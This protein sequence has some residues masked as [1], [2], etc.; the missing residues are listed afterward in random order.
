[1]S[2]TENI[3]DEGEDETKKIVDEGE[4]E[5]DDM[6]ALFNKKDSQKDE[7]TGI[8]VPVNKKDLP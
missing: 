1:M 7:A 4:D 5:T 6:E 8:K 2:M 3:V